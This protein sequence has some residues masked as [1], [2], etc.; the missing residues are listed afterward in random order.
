[1]QQWTYQPVFGAGG[2]WTYQFYDP[3]A[4]YS[5]T[6]RSFR[7]LLTQTGNP[8]R[9]VATGD[10]GAGWRFVANLLG[11]QVT[12]SD[13]AHHASYDLFKQVY[14]RSLIDPFNADPTRVD[15]NWVRQQ[16]AQQRSVRQPWWPDVLDI[17]ASAVDQFKQQRASHAELP[18]PPPPAKH[19]LQAIGH[20]GGNQAQGSVADLPLATVQRQ[21]RFGVDWAVAELQRRMRGNTVAAMP[22][23]AVPHPLTSLRRLGQ[24][25]FSGH[26]PSF[27][28]TSLKRMRVGPSPL[29]QLLPSHPQ[30]LTPSVIAGYQPVGQTPHGAGVGTTW[31]DTNGVQWVGQQGAFGIQGVPTGQRFAVPVANPGPDF[32][33]RIWGHP[34]CP[35]GY[36]AYNTGNGYHCLPYH[37]YR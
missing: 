9:A 36:A 37:P 31:V 15:S 24:A 5:V 7:D 10:T 3:Q 32:G 16:A 13:N 8:L 21:A 20:L 29:P 23:V 28:L 26:D 6:V 17:V 19:P 35:P 4:G 11:G 27:G 18:P 25:Q 2:G 14:T 33:P 34:Q 30:L 12:D 22:A 1:M